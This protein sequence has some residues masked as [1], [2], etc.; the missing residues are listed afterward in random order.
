MA[1]N[2]IRTHIVCAARGGTRIQ[3]SVNRAIQLGCEMQA[4]LTFLYVVD[5]EFMKHTSMGRTAVVFDEMD[6]LGEFMMLRLCEY[7]NRQGCMRA[8]YVIRNGRVRN[9]IMSYLHETHPNLLVLGRPRRDSQQVE[10]AAFE[11]EGL[12]RFADEITRTIGV[13]VEL[14]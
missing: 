6:K 9:E 14:V 8:D 12:V 2:E 1:E 3:P 11:S 4:R 7:A 10:P 5:V 13:P